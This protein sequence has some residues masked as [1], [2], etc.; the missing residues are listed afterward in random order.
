MGDVKEFLKKKDLQ[1]TIRLSIFLAILL[2]LFEIL[3]YF[4]NKLFI[5]LI[6]IPILP[7]LHILKRKS[8]FKNAEFCYGKVVDVT[9]SDNDD[10]YRNTKIEFMDCYSK[11]IHQTVLNEHWGDFRYED[12]DKINEFYEE[13][14]K[15]IGKK[16]PLFYK[17]ENP[18]KNIIFIENLED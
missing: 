12:E 13:G 15:R 17:K 11:K 4:W 1:G 10:V 7:L 14:K 5:I 6:W 8:F 18:N 16:V 2:I 9:L 3:L